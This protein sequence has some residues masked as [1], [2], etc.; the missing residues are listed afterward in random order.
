[1]RSACLLAKT[2]LTTDSRPDVETFVELASVCQDFHSVLS[3][4]K[5]FSKTLHEYINDQCRPYRRRPL[6]LATF[7]DG[8]VSE[9]NQRSVLGLTTLHNKLFIVYE[10]TPIIYVYTI[11]QPYTKL[12]NIHIDGIE[13]LQDI[14]ACSINSCLYVADLV[15]SGV[16]KAKTDYKF[17]PWKA[18][19][20]NVRSLSVTSE[21]HVV[22]LVLSEPNARKV[23]IFDSNGD[24]L[25]TIQLPDNILNPYYAVQAVDKSLIF[26][27][28]AGDTELHRVCEVSNEGII[29]KSYGGS[30]GCELGQ[31]NQP[32]Y[33]ALGKESQVFV[34][35]CGNGRVLLLD[36]QLRIQRVLLT[37]SRD[38]PRCLF[39][40][41]ATAQLMVGF[42]AGQVE[43]FT[44]S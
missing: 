42:L 19:V 44:L 16:W 26:C 20:K 27:H 40:D 18:E 25:S 13:N 11:R 9:S 38:K 28:G 5:W 33:M 32:T 2:I 6:L 41:E 15:S 1:M 39:Y 37:W 8:Q 4:R 14:A 43:I 31:L 12:A 21:G 30:R 7:D 23:Y 36:K 22:V 24:E 29:G 17:D 34:A 3:A 35:D 10:L